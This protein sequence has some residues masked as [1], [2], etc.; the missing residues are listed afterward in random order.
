M[1]DD[2]NQI[3]IKLDTIAI[4]VIYELINNK[5]CK[6]IWSYILEYENNN[7]P[8]PNRRERVGVIS[9]MRSKTIFAEETI[10]NT[11]EDIQNLSKAK[12]KDSLHLSCAIHSECKFFITCDNGLLRTINH[13]KVALAHILGE[14]QIIS[15]LDFIRKGMNIDVI[16]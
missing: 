15:P 7:N 11:A 1:F 12:S 14:I 13:N 5:T 10:I 9:Q 8:F 2:Q 6:L 4:D 16:G 3:S